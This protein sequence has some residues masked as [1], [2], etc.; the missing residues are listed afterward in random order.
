M[1]KAR[2]EYEEDNLM[3]MRVTKADKARQAKM[4]RHNA[5]DDILNFGNYMMRGE[6]G[7]AF[8]AKR[9]VFVLLF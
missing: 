4:N 9:F 7:E 2:E 8:Q 5:I 1:N 6:D 3:R